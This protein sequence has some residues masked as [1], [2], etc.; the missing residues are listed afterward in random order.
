MSE[1]FAA[2]LKQLEV[3]HR[4]FTHALEGLS[5]EALNWSPG[6]EVNSLAALAAHTAGSERYWIGD[7]IA[8]DDSHRDRDAEF[9]TQANNAEELIA[10]LEASLAHSRG[11]VQSLTLI[12]IEE[13]RVTNDQ[14]EV[15][16]AWALVHA[17]E[18]VAIHVGHAQLMRQ[19]WDTQSR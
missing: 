13:A 3:L 2:Y 9:R 11:V 15:T 16:V 4:D 14:R 7:V 1:V 17:L 8:R 10:R 5:V 6:P 18:H 12:E 19:W